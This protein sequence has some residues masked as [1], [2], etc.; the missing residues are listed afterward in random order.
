MENL[1]TKATFLRNDFV[2]LL[3][4]IDPATKPLWGKMNPQ[5]MIEHMSYAMR[6]ASGKDPYTIVTAEEHL[7]KMQ[8]FLMSEKPFRENTPNQLLPD[9]PAPTK[10]ESMQDALNDLQAEIDHFFHV[11][12]TD[13]QKTITNPFFGELN[14]DMQVQLLHKHAWHHL[15]QFGITE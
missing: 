13:P 15:R 7:P 5:Q 9:E 8:A 4:T 6:Q 12:G 2:K 1:G 3:A 14:Y 10:H 11:F